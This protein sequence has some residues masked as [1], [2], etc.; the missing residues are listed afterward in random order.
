VDRRATSAS[1]LNLIERF[2]SELTTR[3]L[4]R[5]AVTSVRELERAIDGYIERRNEDPRPFT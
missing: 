5:L 4:R 1:W 2:F 3:E